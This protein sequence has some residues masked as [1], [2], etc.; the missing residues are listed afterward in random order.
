M[1]QPV[2]SKNNHNVYKNVAAVISMSDSPPKKA[3]M[4][5]IADTTPANSYEENFPEISVAQFA[6]KNV[7][8]SRG[9]FRKTK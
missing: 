3:N 5:H 7:S 4:A 8:K 6:T 2:T 9:D 1:K